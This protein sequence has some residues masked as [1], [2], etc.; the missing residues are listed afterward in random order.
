M[1]K[2]IEEKR[3]Y[4]RLNNVLE[5]EYI[6]PNSGRM[7]TASTKD[8]SAVGLRFIANEKLE[9]GATLEIKLKLPNVQNAIHASGRV[10]WSK[11]A[12][13]ENDSPFDVGVE[14]LKIEE[15]N[16]NTFLKY[17]CDLIYG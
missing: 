4:L 3:K 11:K 9:K 13:L 17:L 6:L 12:S 16:K 10:A 15:D 8:I 5:V 14:F 7:Y 2:N 1:E